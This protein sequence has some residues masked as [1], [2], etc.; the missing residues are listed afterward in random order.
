MVLQPAT[1]AEP[2]SLPALN[3]TTRPD[4]TAASAI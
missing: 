1:V 4:S 3:V 2:N